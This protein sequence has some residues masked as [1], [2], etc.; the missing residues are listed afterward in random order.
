LDNAPVRADNIGTG[1]GEIEMTT[2]KIRIEWKDP[3]SAKEAYESGLRHGL[4][5]AHVDPPPRQG[6]TVRVEL[7]LTFADTRFDVEGVVT[8]STPETTAV[9]VPTVPDE[10]VAF[11]IELGGVDA[12]TYPP[13]DEE[14]RSEYTAESS[15]RSPIRAERVHR[16]VRA[17]RSKASEQDRERRKQMAEASLD[18]SLT[19]D[20]VE[21]AAEESEDLETTEPATE[22]APETAP[23]PAPEPT[24]EP[25][26]E[27]VDETS[28]EPLLSTEFVAP[29]RRSDDDE[30][31]G[32]PVPHRPGQNRPGIV[33]FS[34]D[35]EATPMHQVFL[36]L[37]AD[38]MT[39]VAVI[40]LDDERSW[41]YLIEGQPVQFVTDPPRESE[42]ILSLLTQSK[43]LLEPVADHAALLAEV[44]AQPVELVLIQL[45][46]VEEEQ[47]A[48]VRRERVRL[49]TMRLLASQEGRI[50]FYSVGELDEVVPRVDADII[51][52]VWRQARSGFSHLPQ[53]RIHGHYV[54]LRRQYV[55]LTSAGH[56]VAGRLPI[57]GQ[58]RSFVDKL[59]RPGRQ[60]QRLI[61]GSAAAERKAV[62]LLMTLRLLGV[63]SLSPHGPEDRKQVELERQLR[64]RFQRMELDHFG[65]LG[66][67]WSALPEELSDACTSAEQEM[68]EFSVLGDSIT[69]FGVMRDAFGQRIDEIRG[70]VDGEERRREYRAT[71]IPVDDRSMASETYLK[72]GETALFRGEAQQARDSFRRLM[73]LEGDEDNER[74]H[75]AR[76]ALMALDQNSGSSD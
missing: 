59:R 2:E 25:P 45:G 34:E 31:A 10:V 58:Q 22:P 47:L 32:I 35:L 36:R 15:V 41:A 65:F 61:K 23:A 16:V 49:V 43:A 7:L 33:E 52:T 53:P 21:A 8:T 4:V 70:L 13:G 44:T 50:R 24:A 11:L 28:S 63:V 62:E 57:S 64:E 40:D 71:L 9:W 17:P 29:S 54:G 26:L 48:E 39:G 3:E 42:S 75:R 69:N 73:E 66:L 1:V 51:D 55:S 27:V 14:E 56:K 30:A 76:V 46:L 74:V 12:P 6:S 5:T 18:S 60:V 20:Q 67:H 68:H 37:F 19:W 72:Q 38:E